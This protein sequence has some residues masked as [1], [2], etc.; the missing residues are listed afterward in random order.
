MWLGDARTNG[1]MHVGCAKLVHRAN[2]SGEYTCD[3]AAPTGVDR[4]NHAAIRRCKQNRC[5]IGN[6]DGDESRRII[7]H[8]GIGLGV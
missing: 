8:Q 1:G 6:A 2:G 3:H 7:G 5:A 4:G